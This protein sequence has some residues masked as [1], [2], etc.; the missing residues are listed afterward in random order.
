MRISGPGPPQTSINSMHMI[1]RAHAT[2]PVKSI[3]SSV[4]SQ[5]EEKEHLLVHFATVCTGAL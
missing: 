5:L 4:L 1:Y 2:K 3:D